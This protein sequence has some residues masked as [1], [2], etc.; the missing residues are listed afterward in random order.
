MS[1]RIIVDHLREFV[2]INDR[3]QIIFLSVSADK[4]SFA[5]LVSMKLKL[6]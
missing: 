2:R 4:Y 5:V 6:N 1:G 3:I